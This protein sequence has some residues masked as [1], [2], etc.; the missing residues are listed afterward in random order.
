VP[1]S[2]AESRAAMPTPSQTIGPFF[3]IG[4]FAE[5]LC[6][7]VDQGD[8]DA[9][10][11]GGILFDGEGTPVGDA[12]V[13]IWQ[14]NRAG[15]YAHPEDDREE[16]PLEEGFD[17]FGR[18]P[19]DGDGHYEF[20]TVKPGPV[21]APGGGMQAPHIE[22]SVFARGL[23]KRLATRIYFPDETEANEA[24]PVLS[25]IQDP[26]ERTTLVAREEN[27][28]LRFDIHLQGDEQTTFFDV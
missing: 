2:A 23:L 17:G 18:C 20:V 6:E 12:L 14:A 5:E 27:A 7:L 11:I 10:R 19:T 1:S 3:R 8:R 4:S 21:P 16:V 9:I 13:E 22:V 15:R 24:D 26:A 25:S 28:G